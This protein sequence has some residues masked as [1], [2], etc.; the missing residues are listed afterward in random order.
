MSKTLYTFI[1]ISLSCV[2]RDLL[3]KSLLTQIQADF[4]AFYEV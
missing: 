3:N 1:Q 4:W 2:L